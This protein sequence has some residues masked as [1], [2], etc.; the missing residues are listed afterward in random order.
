M[1]LD[2][3]RT[4]CGCKGMLV[5]RL[6]AGL[7]LVAFGVMHLV[8]AMPM[9]PLVEAAGLPMP[10]VMAIVAPLAQ[11]VAG[12]MLLSGAFARVGAVIAIGTMAGAIVTHVR[13]ADD[14]W[15]IATTDATVGPW[16][17]PVFMMYIALVI[18]AFSVVVLWKGAG[19]M[20]LDFR[21]LAGSTSATGTASADRSGG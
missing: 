5:V 7:P 16:P 12:L 13:I 2:A 10:G 21:S 20:S 6:L 11:L 4:T 15:P 17:E 18:L 8:G 3:L 14:A 19:A 1:A 9:K